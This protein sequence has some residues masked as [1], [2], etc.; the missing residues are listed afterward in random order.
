M[1]KINVKLIVGIRLICYLS[2]YILTLTV[3]YWCILHSNNNPGR[4]VIGRD[5]C[6]LTVLN[7]LS[8]YL[9]LEDTNTFLKRGSHSLKLW[10]NNVK[11]A[12][13]CLYYFLLQ[14]FH[15]PFSYTTDVS[16]KYMIISQFFW[17]K[18]CF[19]CSEFHRTTV[20]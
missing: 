13:H 8:W 2:R 15:E 20:L 17:E 7:F 5:F 18:N 16:E 19:I 11:K 4:F 14:D 9:V 6:R 3:I 12:N 10:G 1:G